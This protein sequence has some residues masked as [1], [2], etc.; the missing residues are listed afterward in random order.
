MKKI[1]F[2]NILAAF[3]LLPVFSQADFSGSADISIFANIPESDGFSSD[4]SRADL[5]IEDIG[6]MSALITKLDSG[7]ES[8]SFSAWFSMKEYPIGQGL[9]AASYLNPTQTGAV[10]ELVSAT[11]DKIYSFDLMRLSANVYLTDNIS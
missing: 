3:I 1:V 9:L 8:T 10:Y 5:G 6:M 4:L 7:D 11:G 2:F